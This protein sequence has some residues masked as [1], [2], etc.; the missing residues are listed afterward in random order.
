MT[1][2][3]PIYSALGL[4]GAAGFRSPQQTLPNTPVSGA[5]LV[6]GAFAFTRCF[7]PGALL[8]KTRTPQLTCVATTNCVWLVTHAKKCTQPPSHLLAVTHYPTY[9][10]G[11]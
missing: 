9:G 7:L 5:G 8:T 10:T 6:F 4:R 3:G 1:E 11:V 2:A